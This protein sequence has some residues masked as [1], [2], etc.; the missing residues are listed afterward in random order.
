MNKVIQTT[1]LSEEKS[2]KVVMMVRD[3]GVMYTVYCEGFCEHII[4]RMDH[5]YFNDIRSA[6]CF[7]NEFVLYHINSD[8]DHLNFN[9]YN[10]QSKPPSIKDLMNS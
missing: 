10:N 1:V 5:H 2:V 7:A 9:A 8:A 6:V 3:L 4:S